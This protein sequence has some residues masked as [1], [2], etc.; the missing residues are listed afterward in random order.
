M[1]AFID[2]SGQVFGRLTVLSREKNGGGG[3]TR[4]RCGCACGNETVVQQ[5][6][7]RSGNTSSCG[8]LQKELVASRLSIHGGSGTRLYTIW[9][10]MKDRCYNPNRAGFVDYGA[11]GI[12]ICDEWRNDF[13][14][15]REWALVSG[16]SDRL[17]ID[18]VDVDG[19]YEPA[20]CRWAT[21]KQQRQE[22]NR[23][24]RPVVQDEAI[25]YPRITAAAE[26]TGVDKTCIY[27]VLAGKTKTAGGHR[28]RYA[29]EQELEVAREMGLETADLHSF[30]ITK[31]QFRTT[32]IF[33]RL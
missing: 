24:I 13:T 15:F 26:A 28:W 19:N 27:S 11:R 1:P 4:W 6:K 21:D 9:S 31:H 2:L 22:N 5:S 18:R 33:E 3:H 16:Y 10:S 29:T 12:S 23:H 7:L 20:N 32:T 14:V 17:S 30:E 8:C 25:F